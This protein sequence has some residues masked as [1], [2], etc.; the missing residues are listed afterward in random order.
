MIKKINTMLF[1]IKSL[2]PVFTAI[3]M[4]QSVSHHQ[5][6]IGLEKN[7]KDVSA[8]LE[9]IHNTTTY[10]SKQILESENF[11]YLK[12]YKVTPQDPFFLVKISYIDEMGNLDR[13]E[14]SPI[15]ALIFP[16]R[17]FDNCNDDSCIN[18]AYKKNNGTDD[19]LYNVHAICSRGFS[20]KRTTIF[21][22]EDCIFDNNGMVIDAIA[23]EI[24][25]PKRK[26]FATQYK[27]EMS[28]FYN[29]GANTTF[30]LIPNQTE[31][32]LSSKVMKQEGIGL[33]LLST[34]HGPVLANLPNFTH[35]ENGC[36]DKKTF[37]QLMITEKTKVSN[38]NAFNFV[39][40]RQQYGNN[41]SVLMQ[42]ADF[43]NPKKQ[44]EVKAYVESIE[45]KNIEE[46]EN[47]KLEEQKARMLTNFE[48]NRNHKKGD[49]VLL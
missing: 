34:L 35:G 46:E 32:L 30:R 49:Y 8:K 26:S 13:S 28:R 10:V 25:A 21:S 38:N 40:N 15:D 31:D 24:P 36:P 42:Q 2:F 1:V 14:I 41:N 22:A 5:L 27:N 16:A 19:I 47:K 43:R 17:S 18:V 20:K 3:S 7:Q 4:D 9:I 33:H 39:M 23:V 45:R 6:R 29:D 48:E 12:P 11:S 37:E 44:Q